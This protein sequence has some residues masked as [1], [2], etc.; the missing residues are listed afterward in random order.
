METFSPAPAPNG[1]ALLQEASQNGVTLRSLLRAMRG[2]R[3]APGL[4][5]IAIALVAGCPQMDTGAGTETGSGIG[6]VAVGGNPGGAASGP[7]SQNL[8]SGG[9]NSSPGG[10]NGPIVNQPP[11]N[12]IPPQPNVPPIAAGSLRIVTLGDSVTEGIGDESGAAGGFPRRLVEKINAQR[13]GSTMLNLGRSGWTSSELLEGVAPDANQIDAAVAARPDIVCLW[14]GSNDLWRLYEYGPETGTTPDLESEDLTAFAANIETLLSRLQQTGAALFVGLL[15]DQ[16]LRPVIEDRFTLPNTTV[17]ERSQM[18]AQ[19]VRYNN[20]IIA[21]AQRHGATVIDF[22]RTSIFTSQETLD[23]DGIH[24]N[25]AGY[26]RITEM[27]FAAM[28]AAI[29][30]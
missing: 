9:S 12:P 28:Q 27:W 21:A 2:A 14:I 11:V 19:V 6:S 29:A 25:A 17:A 8:P 16:S 4:A 24:P 30:R 5:A 20:V 23:P 13:P 15:D 3:F 26:D 22:Y 7:S 18:S 10:G 1:P